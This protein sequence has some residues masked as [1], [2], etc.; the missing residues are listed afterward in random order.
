[1]LKKEKE[2]YI[3]A[4]CG[5]EIYR[6]ASQCVGKNA[7]CG[8]ECHAN[9]KKGL[10]PYNKGVKHVYE[11][12]CAVCGKMITGEKALVARRKYCSYECAHAAQK[13]E[14]VSENGKY[15]KLYL[16]WCGMKRRCYNSR[17]KGY[18]RYGGRGIRVCKEWLDSYP[19]FRDWAF[20]N[21][22]RDGVQIDRINNDGNYEPENCRWSERKEQCNNRSNTVRIT[23]D[24]VTKTINGWAEG[25]GVPRNTI[26]KRYYAGKSGLDLIKKE[27]EDGCP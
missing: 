21:R 18:N 10:A 23:I 27:G 11:K 1:M 7:F 19:S 24:G 5:K 14:G 17:A 16:V 3:C 6:L 20:A 9:Y 2:L 4:Y 15:T 25:S 12:P 13:I 8:K 22:Y 26:R